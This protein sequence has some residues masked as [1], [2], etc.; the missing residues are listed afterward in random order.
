M[1]EDVSICESC[2][3]THEIMAGDWQ[4]VTFQVAF[5]CFCGRYPWGRRDVVLLA[6]RAEEPD[7]WNIICDYLDHEKLLQGNYLRRG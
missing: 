1:N 6:A 5:R 2:F 7:S 4:G 3:L